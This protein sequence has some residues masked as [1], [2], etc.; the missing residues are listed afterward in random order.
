MDGRDLR[1][2][3]DIHA[4]LARAYADPRFPAP[5]ATGDVRM[6]IVNA[7]WVAGIERVPD[8]GW[9]TRMCELLP[10]GS[11][12]F[13]RA[14]AEDAPRFEPDDVKRTWG[15]PC[16]APMVRRAACGKP[17]KI[18]VRVADPADG[19]WHYDWYCRKHEE[20]ATA[21]MTRQQTLRA[22]GVIPEPMPNRGGVGPSYLSWSW[23]EQYVRA[24]PGWEPPSVGICADDWPV[25][26]RVTPAPRKPSL[27]AL[28]GEGQPGDGYSGESPSL[29][30]IIGDV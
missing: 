14:V 8:G 3:L 24:R 27:V 10:R 15:G 26:E 23:P 9:Y 30:L 6:F 12:G 29:R 2:T 13:W 7:I 25:M 22:T 5:S 4:V 21:E 18:R 19:T 20:A 28:P 1:R 11:D 16:P 17:G